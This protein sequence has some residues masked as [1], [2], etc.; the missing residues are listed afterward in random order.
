MIGKREYYPTAFLKPGREKSVLR[1][2]PWVFSGAIAHWEGTPQMGDVVGIRDSR[3]QFLGWGAY[4][5]KSKI[6]IRI[7]SWDENE[8]INSAF[9]EKRL[10][11]AINYRKSNDLIE[12]TNAY[13]LVHAESDGLPGLIV[14]KYNNVLVVQILSAGL[15]RWLSDIA[16][17]LEKLTGLHTIYERSDADVRKLEG[18][19][20]RRGFIRGSQSENGRVQVVEN[21]IHYFVDFM[22]GHKTGFYLDQRENRAYVRANT[23]GKTVL[24]CFSYT[25]GFT[26]AALKGGATSVTAVETSSYARS[27]ARENIL[28]NKLDENK[29]QFV[30]EDVF[31]ALRKFRDRGLKFDVII[32]DPP[33]F[34]PTAALAEKA[35][36][37][38][39]DINLLAMKLLN[40]HGKLVT[41]SCSGGIS[42]EL[43]QKIVAGAAVDAGIDGKIV[44]RLFQGVDHPVSLA[45]PEGLY[46]K[47]LVIEVE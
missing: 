43:F 8:K 19:Q 3:K 41:F 9:F 45:F 32:L 18:L 22:K 21:G 6:R 34:A 20:A 10:I 29:V 42:V 15:E 31:Q 38:Y 2:H 4:S 37:G 26:L 25:G 27:L 1:R 17:I 16:E 30:D 24:D 44:R 14:D 36:R 28:L 23:L 33:K 13:R 46:L 35:A 5:P 11:Q 12:R 7:Y 40:H 39:K 47:G